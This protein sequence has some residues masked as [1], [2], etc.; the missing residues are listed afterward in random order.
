MAEAGR[1]HLIV[2]NGSSPPMNNNIHDSPHSVNGAGEEVELKRTIGLFS[3]VGLI[4]GTIVGSGIFV[5]PTGVLME[6]GSIGSS[7]IVWTLCGLL[8]LVGAL[9]FA[10]LGVTITR[11]GGM[12]AYIHVRFM[13]TLNK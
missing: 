11:S 9:C 1:S 13:V 12:Y 6:S 8:V 5:S 3:G 4:L 7:L 10:E 2:P